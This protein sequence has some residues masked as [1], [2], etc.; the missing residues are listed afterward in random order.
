MKRGTFFSFANLETRK[1]VGAMLLSGEI[2][3]EICSCDVD[4]Q[5]MELGKFHTREDM[6]NDGY[7]ARE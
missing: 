5:T 3:V 4:E 1:A 6:I 2:T 7:P